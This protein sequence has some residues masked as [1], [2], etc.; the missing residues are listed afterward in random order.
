MGTNK[1]FLP[2]GRTT[3]L[4]RLLETLSLGGM[5]RVF[6]VG[7]GDDDQL[8]EAV[9]SLPTRE[10][11]TSRAEI[12]FVGV[13]P[14]PPDMRCSIENGLARIKQESP[15]ARDGWMVVPADH[16]LAKPETVRT[17]VEAWRQRPEGILIP[18]ISGRRGHPTL[19]GWPLAHDCRNLPP[20]TG[21]NMLVRALANVVVEIPVDD[22]SIRCDLDTPADYARHLPPA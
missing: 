4:E 1:L 7:R 13:L 20:E 16:P 5:D 17:L 10:V 2:W 19:L 15:G 22:P 11:A 18:T 3:V 21:L 14:A 8:R 9:E 6:V 12:E